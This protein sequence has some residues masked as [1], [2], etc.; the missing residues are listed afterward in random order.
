MT[1]QK[2]RKRILRG[3]SY[4]REITN[5][6]TKWLGGIG[7]GG[8]LLGVDVRSRR[9]NSEGLL[10]NRIKKSFHNDNTYSTKSNI[11]QIQIF[12]TVHDRK[13]NKPRRD[14]HSR[15]GKGLNFIKIV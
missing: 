9:L 4:N 5:L 3:S 14:V 15:G 13:L 6:S 2:Y 8:V 1:A 11:D 12:L 10:V 7:G